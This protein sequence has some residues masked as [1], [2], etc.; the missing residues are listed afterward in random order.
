MVINKA[1]HQAESQ[2]RI[3]WMNNRE[4]QATSK[5]TDHG[6]R[7][8]DNGCVQVKVQVQGDCQSPTVKVAEIAN[9]VHPCPSTSSVSTFD[10][11]FLQ[12]ARLCDGDGRRRRDSRFVICF[13]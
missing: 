9:L 1:K 3:V 6:S 8:T 11:T 7:I 10:L 2:I 13:V 4:C 12:N 5:I